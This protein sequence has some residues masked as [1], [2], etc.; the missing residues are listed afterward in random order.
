MGD[1]GDAIK[2]QDILGKLAAE[3]ERR[4]IT[5]EE[6][7]RLSRISMWQGLT[8]NEEGEA[9]VH[10]LY[11][12]QLAPSWDA[13]PEWPVV[14][15]GPAVKLPS[16][17][18][19]AGT[20]SGT[21]V[22]VVLPDMQVGFY[23]HPNGDLEPTHDPVA[24][25]VALQV[26]K[27]AKPDKVVL[28]GD[29]LDLPEFGKYRLSPAFAQTTQATVD[30]AT[31]IAAQVRAA[32]PHAEIVWLA[33]NHEERLPNYLMDNAVAAFGL[34]QGMKPEG[35]PVMSVPYLCRLDE[36]GIVYRPGYPACDEWI[37]E[38]L[39]VI[40]GDR[41]RSK[42]STAH[43]YLNDEKT[44][45]IYGHI[46]RIERAHKTRR[47]HDGPREIMAATPGCL[48]RIDGAVP[49][50]KQGND[51]DGRPLLGHYEDWQ[52]GLAI[53]TY[54]ESGDFDYEQVRIWQGQARWRG[55]R[56]DAKNV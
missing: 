15:P 39:R 51:L 43:L 12:F 28:V 35:W 14:Q 53:V 19:K 5:V 54:D 1:L 50:T 9:E 56:Y 37:T 48:A 40:H 29:N 30:A 10:D 46:H 38:K 22:C 13:G 41:V 31:E 47:D 11:G 8:K 49:S 2:G 44:S 21:K 7:G 6:I 33:G 23:R 16:I 25:D 17:S 32:A 20:D 34:R 45:V 36:F 26:T 3:L 18:G 4:G 52:Q 27:A 42:G 24:I 55:R